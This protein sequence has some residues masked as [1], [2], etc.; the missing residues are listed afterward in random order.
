MNGRLSQSRVD[1]G[2]SPTSPIIAI[3]SSFREPIKKQHDLGTWDKAG[4]T[5]FIDG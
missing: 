2:Q 5:A 1:S 3:S 4:L